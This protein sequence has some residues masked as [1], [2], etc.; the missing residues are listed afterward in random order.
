MS[1]V[2]RRSTNAVQYPLGL[3]CLSLSRARSHSVQPG[4][5]FSPGLALP[6]HPLTVAMAAMAVTI[7][8]NLLINCSKLSQKLPFDSETVFLASFRLP[9]PQFIPSFGLQF[10][11]K[12]RYFASTFGIAVPQLAGTLALFSWR[13]RLAALEGSAPLRRG[14]HLRC[15]EQRG[16]IGRLVVSYG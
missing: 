11:N 13:L 14:V 3:A 15:E 16:W 8:N 12:L 9:R 5:G 2:Y 7:T 10:P 6:M 1:P 4:L